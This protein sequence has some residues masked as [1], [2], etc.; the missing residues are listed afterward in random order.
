MQT[1]VARAS[2]QNSPRQPMWG[3]SHCTGKVDATMPSEPVMSIHELARSWVA[4]S[5]QRRKP[6]SGAIRQALT[7]MPTSTREASR[8][9]KLS[10]SAKAAQ[11][12]TAMTR[13]PSTT[14][15]GPCRSS[16][17]PMGSWVR[18]KP[19]K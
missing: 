2:A 16:H 11:P 12:S 4:G 8:P 7:P 15:R 18:A 6:V 1:S 17:W 14:R 5:S 9:A 3:S 19:K 13:K 10:A